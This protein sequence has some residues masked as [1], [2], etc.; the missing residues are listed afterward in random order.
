MNYYFNNYSYSIIESKYK[1]IYHNKID[2]EYLI[3]EIKSTPEYN[4]FLN[5]KSSDIKYAIDYINTSINKKI[6]STKHFHISN[7]NNTLHTITNLFNTIF[8]NIFSSMGLYSG[9]FSDEYAFKFFGPLATSEAINK[10]SELISNIINDLNLHCITTGLLFNLNHSVTNSTTLSGKYHNYNKKG[11]FEC[12]TYKMTEHHINSTSGISQKYNGIYKRLIAHKTEY[13][14]TH[15]LNAM[16]SINNKQEAYTLPCY[17]KNIGLF[18]LSNKEINH[19]SKNLYDNCQTNNLLKSYTKANHS[20]TIEASTYN[21]I[22]DQ[23]IFKNYIEYLFGFRTSDHICSLLD[24]IKTK[25]T[26]CFMQTGILELK[27]LNINEFTSNMTLVLDCPAIN[28][29]DDLL[30]YALFSLANT[31]NFNRNYLKQ[32]DSEPIVSIFSH[33]DTSNN[34]EYKKNTN[35]IISEA[36]NRFKEFFTIINN[37]TIPLIEEL[38]LV[39]TSELFSNSCINII[40]LYSIY[41]HLQLN[42][43]SF[44]SPT[45]EAYTPAIRQLLIKLIYNNCNST[46]YNSSSI[47]LPLFPTNVNSTQNKKFLYSYTQLIT[48]Y[49]ESFNKED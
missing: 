45:Y 12:N 4:N 19:L 48:N 10:E 3:K 47:K 22:L 16:G 39:V 9:L 42:P 5:I 17:F 13:Y 49:F 40:D 43:I 15:I 32:K 27:D 21:S 8:K 46:R 11:Y 24:K 33:L 14:S 23:F 1:L 44:S 25:D 6:Y 26:D 37:V 18:L 20:Y 30:D 7:I 41:L 34:K 36:T 35:Y 2:V 28:V 31:Q 29:R 38:W